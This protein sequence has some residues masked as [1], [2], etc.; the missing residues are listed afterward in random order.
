MRMYHEGNRQLQQRFGSTDLADRLLE[1]T[2]HTEFSDYDK[3]FIESSP[4]F[5]LATADAEGRPDCSFKSGQ[6]GFVK[7]VGLQQLMFPDYDG[8]GMFKSMGNIEVNPAVGLL[9]ITM[10]E[11]PQ[12]IRVNGRA[13]VLKDSPLLAEFVGAQL[14]IQVDVEHIFPNC[15]R[16]IPDLAN[17]TVSEYVPA[18]DKPVKEPEWKDMDLFKDVVP[19]R[20]TQD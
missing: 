13:K 8:N 11:K 7:V 19:P 2:H 10:G 20:F 9:F 6:P 15:P 12:R 1:V 17:Q 4:F 5:F 16:Y 14:L 3:N 18:A